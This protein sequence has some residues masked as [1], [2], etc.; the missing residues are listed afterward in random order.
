MAP[1]LVCESHIRESPSLVAAR[2]TGTSAA[3]RVDVEQRTTKEICSQDLAPLLATASGLERITAPMPAV[4][5]DTLLCESR[6]DTT[7]DLGELLR[8]ELGV[9]ATPLFAIHPTRLLVIVISFVLTLALG[10]DLF[11]R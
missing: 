2:V 1:A 11:V 6:V 8:S 10:I 5:L 3:N 7:V 4:E 9:E